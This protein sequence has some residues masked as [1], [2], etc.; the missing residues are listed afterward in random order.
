MSERR[1]LEFGLPGSRRLEHGDACVSPLQYVHVAI[2]I[3]IVGVTRGEAR[4]GTA[5][6]VD[7]FPV[8]T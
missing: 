6:E 4:I 1:F 8:F 3:H 7:I 5:E 2:G